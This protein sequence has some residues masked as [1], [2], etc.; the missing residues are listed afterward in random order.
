MSLASC[1]LGKCFIRAL[2]TRTLPSVTAQM[3]KPP[4]PHT[5]G[6]EDSAAGPAKCKRTEHQAP[7]ATEA[8]GKGSSNHPELAQRRACPSKESQPRNTNFPPQCHRK[9]TFPINPRGGGCQNARGERPQCS[10]SQ[11]PEVFPSYLKPKCVSP[12]SH[13][14]A[15]RLHPHLQLDLQETRVPPAA[16]SSRTA[17]PAAELKAESCSC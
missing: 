4:Q 3:P 5:P 6:A 1:L 7:E 2:L 9:V 13:T 11:P 14:V 17:R 8:T 12:Q 10:V 15:G 16:T